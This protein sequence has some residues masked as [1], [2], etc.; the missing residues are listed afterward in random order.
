MAGNRFDVVFSVP[1][2]RPAPSL[3]LLVVPGRKFLRISSIV[4]A[5]HPDSTQCVNFNFPSYRQ[6]VRCGS[7]PSRRRGRFPIAGR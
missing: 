2:T 3:H 1:A 6:P 4:L 7:S 5:E